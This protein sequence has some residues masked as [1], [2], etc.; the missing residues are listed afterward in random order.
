[1]AYKL[2]QKYSQKRAFITGGGGG[3]GR[4]LSLKLAGDGWTI[5]I[6]DIKAEGLAESAQL[7]EKAGGKAYTY[8]FDVS[9]REEFKKAFDD[10][11]S[12][13]NGID[14]LINNEIG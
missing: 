14:L 1:M 9:K 4:A 10:F 5:G 6:S 11:I 13:T 3:L 2:T 12:K 8:Q 7:I